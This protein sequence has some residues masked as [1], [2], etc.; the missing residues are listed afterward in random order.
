DIANRLADPALGNRV[1]MSLRT[2]I[3]V[4][5]RYHPIKG[6][7]SDFLRTRLMLSIHQDLRNTIGQKFVEARIK[8]QETFERLFRRRQGQLTGALSVRERRKY[9][10]A[11]LTEK[12][13]DS[14]FN[15]FHNKSD[16]FLDAV[17]EGR[18][19][20]VG[21]PLDDT[22]TTY[23]SFDDGDPIDVEPDC[24]VP[25]IGFTSNLG[26]ISGGTLT[27]AD[28]YLGCLHVEH[29]NLFLVGFARPILGNIPSISEMQAQYATGL[30]SGRQ[31]RPR[32]IAAAHRRE[33]SSLRQAFPKL[34]S[35]S[36]YPVEMFPYCDRLARRM[37]IYPIRRSAGSWRS[38]L[39]IWL[40]PASTLHYADESYDAA[41]IARQP[42]HSPAIITL[43][44]LLIKLADL[45]YAPIRAARG[46]RH[47]S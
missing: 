44:L 15:M 19:R 25:T 11:K 36:M 3:R 39:K 10:T 4:S 43:L 24:L 16:D 18:L 23:A 32:D 37:G 8:H 2:G 38:W 9:W 40:S 29:D 26:A 12:S 7:P 41:F 35:E 31:T 14:L 27:P 47:A 45:A 6:V 21:P 1:L 30:L 46:R 28:F 42:I 33:R 13:K 34:D 20:I 17:A 5:P 22:F